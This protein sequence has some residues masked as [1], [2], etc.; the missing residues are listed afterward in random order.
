MHYTAVVPYMYQH[1]ILITRLSELN[2]G[3]ACQVVKDKIV[4]QN[5]LITICVRSV[6]NFMND[7]DC[8]NTCEIVRKQSSNLIFGAVLFKAGLR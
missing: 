5:W 3:F 6:D 7:I 4:L 2:Q 8:F 1:D